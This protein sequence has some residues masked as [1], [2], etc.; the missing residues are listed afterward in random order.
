MEG[1]SSPELAAT[2]A[3]FASEA[4]ASML[5]LMLDG[6]AW[7]LTELS[8]TASIAR[9][10]ASEHADKL[11]DVGL[12]EEVRQ[13]RHRYLR[14]AGAQAADL[15]ESLAAFTG[16]VR[17]A[18]QSLDAQHRDRAMREARTCYRHLAG[19]LGV[20]LTDGMRAQGFIE[21]DFSFTPPGRAW[22]ASLG[23]DLPKH[24]RRTLARPCLDWTERREHLAGLAAD[25]LL[26]TLRENAWIE[27]VPSST[28]AVRLTAAGRE[29]L[30]DLLLADPSDDDLG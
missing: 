20:A 13:G 17:P 30:A 19:R 15:I 18:R 22:L 2:A 11:L 29:G 1:T 12:V 16:R 6:R 23:I 4:R 28:R 24:P 25:M 3:V 21:S 7:T 5:L 10:S 9:S 8:K 14:L 27:I 26:A